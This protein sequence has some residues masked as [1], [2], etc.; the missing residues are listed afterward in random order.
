MISRLISF[1]I[2][3]VWLLCITNVVH[4][5]SPAVGYIFLVLALIFL[6]VWVFFRFFTRRQLLPPGTGAPMMGGVAPPVSGAMPPAEYP[7]GP[8]DPMIA[9]GPIGAPP[10]MTGPNPM[11]LP[12]P[13]A[14]GNSAVPP[15]N[16]APARMGGYGPGY[17]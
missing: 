11:G 4:L 6:S 10:P 16:P 7:M 5:T 14:Y 15:M 12:P 3:Q 1:S 2:H 8:A 13:Q 17:V 9:P